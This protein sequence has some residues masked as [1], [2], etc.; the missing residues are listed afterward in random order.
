MNKSDSLRPVSLNGAAALSLSSASCLG[1]NIKKEDTILLGA[2]R[3]DHALRH[4]LPRAAL[5]EVQAA[6]K[7]DMPCASAFCALVAERCRLSGKMA[8]SPILW[9][10]EKQSQRCRNLLYPPG[11]VELG[12]DPDQIIYAQAESIIPALKTAADAVRSYAV[13]AVILTLSGKNPRGL[14][15]TATRRLSLFARESGVTVFLLRDQLSSLSTAAYSRWQISSAPSR[16]LEANAPGHPV[17]DVKL[18]RH[19]RGI[20]GL[21]SRLEW[22]RDS[23]I[24]K[25]YAPDIGVVPAVS[26]FGTDYQEQRRR[27]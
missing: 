1:D 11:L 2:Q 4:A 25:E 15:L 22:N 9:V 5:H 13:S 26:V 16:P 3:F 21:S 12:I 27:A 10:D 14:D 8:N 20:E 23:R 19:R 6:L 17:F 7:A 18:L 24:F